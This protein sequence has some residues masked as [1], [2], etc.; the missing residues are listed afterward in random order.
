M[1]TPNF[2]N[3]NSAPENAPGKARRSS[4]LHRL[5]QSEIEDAAAPEPGTEPGA[6]PGAQDLAL[7]EGQADLDGA[8]LGGTGLGGAALNG[9]ALDTADDES[10]REFYGRLV[11]LL[12]QDNEGEAK[13]KKGGN[14][15][16]V[17]LRRRWLPALLLT[18]LAFFGLYSVL[19][20]RQF[21]Y[22]A[23]TTLLLPP[24]ES[25][26]N[27]DPFSPLEDSYDTEAQLA[28]IG[29]DQIVNRALARVPADLRQRGWGDPNIKRVSV[30]VN[31]LKSDSLVDIS[32]ASLSPKASVRLVNE[33]VAAYREY[34]KNRYTQNKGENLDLTRERVKKTKSDLANAR[35]ELRDYKERTGVFDATSQQS[36][37]A[38]RINDLETAL[39]TAQREQ[40]TVN[41]DASVQ[42]LRQRAVDAGAKL[43]NILR[44]FDPSAERARIAQ[45]EYNSAQE[46][47]Q[48]RAE[49]L[50]AASVRRVSQ[51]QSDLSQAR[52]VAANLPAAEQDLNRLNERV[53]LL[54]TAYRSASA[55]ADQLSLASGTIAPVAKTLQPTDVGSDLG[56]KKAR[57]LG[58]SLLGALLLGLVCA[59][60]LDRL[61]H[62]VRA[63]RDPEA[64]FEAPVLGALPAIKSSGS[65]FIGNAPKG[66]STRARTATLEACT[67]AQSHILSAAATAG[68]RSILFTSSLPEEG[69][70]QCAANLAAAMAYGGRQ[71]LLIDGDFW[72]PTQHEILRQE[73][74]PGYAQILR[75]EAQL[76]QT[77][78]ATDVPNLHLLS[79]GQTVK[80][81]VNGNAGNSSELIALLAG[82]SH[83]HTLEVLK[84]FFDVIIVDAPPVMSVSDAQLLASLTDATILVAAART[85]RDQ[86]QRAR[87]ML[88]LAGA[89]LLGVVINS[90]RL[91]EVQGWNVD[92]SPE[93]PFSHYSNS[94]STY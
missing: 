91:G 89:D 71:V 46:Q 76:S 74:A 33:M 30:N 58:V 70:S 18:A 44:D 8:G 67:N 36:S 9:G 81:S 11:N 52:S 42:Q 23:S 83:D 31:A 38:A 56:M 14:A 62:S 53:T 1:A 47:A 69:K 73:L 39:A 77:I 61:D 60:G 34:T 59:L 86:V 45:E 7:F 20:P 28:I 40:T 92:F 87:S 90:V 48:A 72:H 78:R 25:A 27:K 88:R 43:R 17:A 94:L 82:E 50:S 66:G 13:R 29:S 35:R 64:L 85:N 37:S 54:E 49:Q 63:A 3:S 51:L 21:T 68:A 24:R 15:L 80:P 32:T 5:S 16:A 57:A 84:R 26:N 19:K 79:A 22:M 12:T 2:R 65:L 41:D 10:M 55:R 6:Q 93:E 75:D 4:P